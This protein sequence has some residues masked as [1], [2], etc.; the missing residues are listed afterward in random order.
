ML[1]HSREGGAGGEL[2]EPQQGSTSP[3]APSTVIS[4][5]AW[6]LTAEKASVRSGPA[7]VPGEGRRMQLPGG[8]H[9]PGETEPVLKRQAGR[10]PALP[11]KP[12]WDDRA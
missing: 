4:L 6:E 2:G 5:Q 10:R 3:G 7:G 9:G 8:S 1:E 12:S 11:G